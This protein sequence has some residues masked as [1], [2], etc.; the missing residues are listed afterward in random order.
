MRLDIICSHIS[1]SSFCQILKRAPYSH[2][3]PEASFASGKSG[4][5]DLLSLT[6]SSFYEK[7][8][9]KGKSSFQLVHA[10]QLPAWPLRAVWTSVELL[11]NY[12]NLNER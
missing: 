11:S 7:P 10:C 9:K 2:L 12:T 5:K 4:S 1:F 3:A 6:Q 8:K